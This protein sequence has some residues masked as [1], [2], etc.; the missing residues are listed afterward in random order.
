M[1]EQAGA[2]VCAGFR[3]VTGIEAVSADRGVHD[4]PRPDQR[5]RPAPEIGADTEAV[6]RDDL[7][8]APTAIAELRGA[9]VID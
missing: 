7:G 6:L 3:G 1:V 8:L 9:G 4:G 2:G 5:A